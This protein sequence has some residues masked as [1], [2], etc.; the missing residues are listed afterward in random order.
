MKKNIIFLTILTF[1][2]LSGLLYC[3]VELIYN[4]RVSQQK[5]SLES[6]TVAF[7]ELISPEIKAAVMK[8]DD[9]ALLYSIEKLSKVNTIK[10]AFI[11]DKNLNVAIHN[12]S[13]KWN[14]KYDEDLYK[15]IV[16]LNNKSLQQSSSYEYVY[17][18]PLND[19]SVLCVKYSLQE[20]FDGF[21]LW[22]IKLYV[23]GFIIVFVVVFVIYYLSKF[24]F[25][26]PFNKTKKY[27]SVNEINKKT[28]YSDIVNMALACNGNQQKNDEDN[29]AKNINL[30]NQIFKTY[31]NLS[32]D[33]FVIL[34]DNAKLVY[35]VDKENIV[36]QKQTLGE[37]IVSLT[38][39]SDLLRNVSL[40]LENHLESINMDIADYKINIIP[41]KDDKDNFIGIIISGNK[42]K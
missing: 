7:I 17:S 1:L 33:I 8:D 10:E 36:L 3:F 18:Q 5:T 29:I 14:K 12:D 13:S 16:S 2:C 35:C 24:F 26:R 22:K 20:I 30:L 19:N 38:K 39:K 37:H 34:D 21:K 42:T 31:L 6:N 9:I 23:Y 25:L 28:I 41:F 32:D 15:N 11:L 4:E 27:L 40:V